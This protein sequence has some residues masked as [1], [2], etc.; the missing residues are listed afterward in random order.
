MFRFGRDIAIYA[1][2]DLLFRLAQLLIIPVYAHLLSLAEFGTWALV[3]VSATLLGMFAALGVHNSVMRFYYDAEVEND[4]QAVLVSTGLYQIVLSSVL[5]VGASCLVL[6]AWREDVGPAV[7][8]ETNLLLVAALTILP[9]QVAQYG[10]DNARLRFAPLQFLL[11]A[12]VKNLFGLLLGLWL[13]TSFDMGVLGILVGNLIASVLAVPIALFVVR[14]DLRLRFPMPLARKLLDFGFPHV[15]AG[16]AY[17]IFGSMDRWM[18]A[19]LSSI[20]QVALFSMAFKLATVLA[21]LNSAF[22]QAWSPFAYRIRTQDPDYRLLFSRVLS[23]WFFLLAF[24]GLAVAVFSREI[25]GLF[26]P[27]VYLAASACLGLGAASFA[28]HGTTLITALC[29]AIEKRTI[30][31]S[32]AAWTA[33][34]ANLLLNLLMIPRFGA[35]GAAASTF[36]AYT[37]LASFLLYW[38]QRLHPLP[39]ERGKLAYASGILGIAVAASFTEVPPTLQNVAIKLALLCLALAGAWKVGFVTADMVQKARGELAQRRA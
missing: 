35:I 8:I 13:I 33:A 17:W 18:L 39:L 23:F 19:Q 32:A 5:I 25:V 29:I 2:I 15:L 10:L 14:R 3:T 37:V 16:A 31:L 21:F 6:T 9:D 12:V 38:S 24:C 4:D 11:I 30:L 7:G 28:L 27:P 22:G 34:V 26:A 20:E 1:G 36:A